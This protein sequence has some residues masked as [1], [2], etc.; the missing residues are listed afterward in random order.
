MRKN[1]LLILIIIPLLVIITVLQVFL[2]LQK[3]KW[4]GLIIPSI[5]TLFAVI[6]AINAMEVSVAIVAF[7]VMS[8]PTV[9]NI[10]IYFACRS[11]FKEKNTNEITKMKITDLE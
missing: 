5:N 9:I 2:S 11:K 1:L 4:L 8:I 7:L 10:G 6:F 3:N